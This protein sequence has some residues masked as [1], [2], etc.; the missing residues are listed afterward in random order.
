[1]IVIQNQRAG[2]F[3]KAPGQFMSGKSEPSFNHKVIGELPANIINNPDIDTGLPQRI[4]VA[5]KGN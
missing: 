2:T 4:D 5:V 3:K 1:V